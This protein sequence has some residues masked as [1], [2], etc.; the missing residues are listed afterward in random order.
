MKSTVNK[1]IY[2]SL[3]YIYD[4]LMKDI[5]YEDWSDFIDEVIQ[6]HYEDAVTLLELGCGTGTFALSLDELDVYDITATDESEAMLEI[7]KTKADYV[8]IEKKTKFDAI[9]ML[10]DSINYTQNHEELVH[11]LKEVK[12]VMNEDSIFVFDFTTPVNS[13]RAEETLDEEGVSGNY[14]YTRENRFLPFENIHYNEFLIEELDETGEV[15]SKHIEV[16]KQR[17]YTLA[18]MKQAVQEAGYELI[19]AYEGFDLIDATEASDRITMVVRL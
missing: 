3:A 2:N 4:D 15:V 9:L 7:A 6:T 10:F 19:A 1:N 18:E 8:N 17:I 11:V 16:H 14:R 12:Q 5:S 13:K